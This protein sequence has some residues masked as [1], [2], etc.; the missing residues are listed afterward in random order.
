MLVVDND[1]DGS[2]RPVV[3]QQATALN[4]RY[5]QEHRT[6][7]SHVRNAILSAAAPYDAIVF[8]DDDQVVTDGWLRH[9]RSAYLAHPDAVVSG[10]VTYLFPDDTPA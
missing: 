7:V 3:E 9:L 4:I 10:R 2:A 6:G 8:L 5:A 1:P